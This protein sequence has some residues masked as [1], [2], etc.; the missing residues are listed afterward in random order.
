MFNDATKELP[1]DLKLFLRKLGEK[2]IF[3]KHVPQHTDKQ[4][5]G[6][7]VLHQPMMWQPQYNTNPILFDRRVFEL[8]QKFQ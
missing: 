4:I 7:I 5:L 2:L 3:L 8:L 6:R 1:C